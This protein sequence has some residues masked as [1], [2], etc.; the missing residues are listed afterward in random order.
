MRILGCV[1]VLVAA[2]AA[3][4]EAVRVGVVATDT[5][6]AINLVPG[7]HSAW[8]NREVPARGELLIFITGTGGRGLGPVAF[9]RTAADHGY[10]VIVPQY[11]NDIAAAVCRDDPEPEAFE[12][13]RREIIEGRDLSPRV[14][15]D[16][17][18]S[19][20]NRIEKLVGWL[21]RHRADEGWGQF[22]DAQGGL[23]WRKTVLTGH[24]QG[25]GHALLM[26]RDRAVA[27]VIATGAPK[28]NSRAL[29][30]PAAWYRVGRTPASRLF[31]FNH[32]QDRQGCSW[33]EQLE[34]IA[35]A[36]LGPMASVDGAQ[37]PYG[38]A[39]ALSTDHSGMEG[40]SVA[41]HTSVIA[42]G[43]VDRNRRV[44]GEMIFKPVWIHMLTTPVE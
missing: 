8:L 1:A 9:L 36:G 38:G 26:A 6:P 12:N 25:G 5:D 19:L 2:V 10:H 23:V 21:A 14:A 15:V 40:D 34:N 20:E 4:A 22:L 30:R 44:V 16:R 29:G 35:A 31:C 37:P 39:R 41:A 13:F 33:P 18:N 7:E 27:R 3:S 32:E 17:P 28:D 11:C 42:G 24:S 43:A